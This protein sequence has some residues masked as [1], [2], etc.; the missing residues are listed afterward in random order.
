M[1]EKIFRLLNVIQQSQLISNKSRRIILRIMGIQV[2]STAEISPMVFFGS[3]K[4]TIGRFAFINV[5]CF[6]DGAGTIHVRDFA[7]IGPYV[8]I[9]TGTH[10]YRNSKIRRRTEDGLI[11]KPVIVEQG[12]WVGMGASIL[13]GVTINEGC[14]IA[15]QALITRTTE[16]NGLYGGVPAKRLKSLS[17]EEDN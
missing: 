5:G 7:R 12:C 8:R 4:I 6:L 14:V 2:D 3:S 16:A 17:T 9:L 11:A 13:P 10:E 1:N 15:A